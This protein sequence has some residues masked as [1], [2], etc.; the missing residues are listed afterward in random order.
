MGGLLNV[1]YG[2]I[3]EVGDVAVLE[4]YEFRV[5]SRASRVVETVQLRVI[6]PDAA[7]DAD[8]LGA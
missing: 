7:A 3:P 1:L 5:L 6:S 8:P 2:N 4:P